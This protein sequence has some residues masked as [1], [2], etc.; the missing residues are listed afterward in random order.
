M[1]AALERPPL[2][3]A[4]WGNACLLVLG[5]PLL[6]L[7]LW[8]NVAEPVPAPAAPA[9]V[10]QLWAAEVSAAPS[11]RPLPTGVQQSLAAAASRPKTKLAEAEAPRL[12]AARQSREQPADKAAARDSEQASPSAPAASSSAAPRAD[13]GE[14]AAAPFN[15]EGA[16]RVM[17]LSWEGQVQSHLARFRRYPE[18]ASRRRRGGVVKLSFVVDAD[19]RVLSSQQLAGSGT[20]SLDR[21]AA[22][23][24]LR[25]QPLPPPPADLLKGGRVSVSLPLRFELSE[26]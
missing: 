1:A 9:A 20:A 10:M 8:L 18:D 19:G 26:I 14:V 7:R 23:M 2:P 5:A 6:A 11:S 13:A 12:L 4:S 25:A 3:L 21:E 16:A 24:L 15:S 17:R 22:A